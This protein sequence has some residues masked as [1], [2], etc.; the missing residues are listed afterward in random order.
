[1]Y[2]AVFSWCER[3]QSALES[4]HSTLEFDL[5]RMNVLLI[6]C[7]QSISARMSALNYVKKNLQQ[8]VSSHSQGTHTCLLLILVCCC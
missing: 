6:L 5:H 4:I 2:H 3:N 1:M 7:T 8:Y